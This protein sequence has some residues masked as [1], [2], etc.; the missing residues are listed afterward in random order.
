MFSVAYRLGRSRPKERRRAKEAPKYPFSRY[1]GSSVGKYL[2]L[3][4]TST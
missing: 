4:R 2:M 1:F 3:T